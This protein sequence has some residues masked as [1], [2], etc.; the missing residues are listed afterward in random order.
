VNK[1]LIIGATSDLAVSY[2]NSI[3]DT[4]HCVLLVR[5]ELKVKSKFPKKSF[6]KIII[7]DLASTKNLDSVANLYDYNYRKIIFFNGVDIIKPIQFYTFSEIQNSFNINVISIFTII[8]KLIKSKSIA[9]NSSLLVIS[10][11]S[12]NIIGSKGHSLYAT[13][14][15]SITGLVKS[16]AIE[17]SKKRIRV[18]SILPGLIK[19]ENLYLKNK[20]L[21]SPEDFEKYEKNY[22]LG[23]GNTKNINDLIDFLL[24]DKSSWITGQNIVIDGGHTILR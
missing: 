11:I 2:I 17:L 3:K 5:N 12:G 14:K 13:T 23:L 19:T 10:S 20:N 22:P 16:L 4:S 15:A 7:T 1:T 8:S 9:N 18:N 21:Q 24:E 6:H